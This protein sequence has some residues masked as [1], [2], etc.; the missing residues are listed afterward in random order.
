M[1]QH[2]AGAAN[3]VWHTV[4]TP[5]VLRGC[6][7]TLCKTGIIMSISDVQ[8]L[9]PARAELMRIVFAAAPVLVVDAY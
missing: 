5:R 9:Q 7:L 4:S 1:S 3:R 8:W 6:K 2:V